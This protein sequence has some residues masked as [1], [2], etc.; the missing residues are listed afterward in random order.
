MS[1]GRLGSICRRW[2]GRELREGS[3]CCTSGG[4]GGGSLSDRSVSREGSRWSGKQLALEKIHCC[5]GG[6]EKKIKCSKWD[7]GLAM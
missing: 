2:R 1:I 3:R 5:G 4:E 7:D 6:E